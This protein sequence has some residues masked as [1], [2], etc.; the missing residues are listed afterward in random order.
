VNEFVVPP[1]VFGCTCFVRDHRPSVGKFDPQAV[2]CIFV[3]YFSSQK[4]YK[5]WCPTERHLFVSMD[6]TFRESEPFYGEKTYLTSLFPD[7]DSPTMDDV[8]R[9]G[10]NSDLHNGSH[11]QQR[12]NMKAVIGGWVPQAKEKEVTT[13]SIPSQVD[14]STCERWQHESIP[15]QIDGS[16]CERWQ[17]QNITQVYTR[18][19]FRPQT[20]KNVHPTT[21]QCSSQVSN[22]D[23]QIVEVSS[24][25]E[26][27]IEASSSADL[28]IAL[29]KDARVKAGVPPPR[30][31]FEHD[32]GNYVSMHCYLPHIEHLLHH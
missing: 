3:G 14:G 17:H 15:S 30:Y 23:Q 18:K 5:C 13:E 11:E 31:G 28:P 26:A 29:R 2:K 8:S 16:T 20:T 7:L 4:G 32:M 19:K 1:K 22:N 9:E 25:S 21:E 12:S 27:A 24:A 10:E 6:V